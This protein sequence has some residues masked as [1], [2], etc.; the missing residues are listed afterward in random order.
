MLVLAS[1]SPRRRRLLE[2]HGVAFTVVESG[3]DESLLTRG[4]AGPHDWVMALAYIKARSVADAINKRS[5]ELACLVLGA[6]TMCL[7]G[8][9]LLGKPSSAGEARLMLARFIDAQHEVVTGVAIVNPQTGQREVFADLAVVRW[10]N[11]DADAVERYIESGDWRGK[12]GGYNL[13]ERV[14]EGWPIEVVGDPASVMGLPVS[15]VIESLEAFDSNEPT[16][17]GATDA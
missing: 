4:Q 7:D 11:V 15:R 12:A 14:A 5:P 10:G 13:A 8:G 1:S 3:I 6:D 16:P 9:K 2:E 17:E